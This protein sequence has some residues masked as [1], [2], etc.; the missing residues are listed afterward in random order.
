MILISLANGIWVIV[1]IL[2]DL[3]IVGPIQDRI[4][5]NILLICIRDSSC[6]PYKAFGFMGSGIDY[7]KHWASG[8]RTFDYW[9]HDQLVDQS[10]YTYT[11]D[12]FVQR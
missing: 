4:R 8:S 9:N 1:T 2:S 5:Q 10:D 3:R 6:G 7:S 12:D 11:T